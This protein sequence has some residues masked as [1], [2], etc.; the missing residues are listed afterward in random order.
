MRV[1]CKKSL[2]K[3]NTV[4]I[5][6]YRKIKLDWAAV[7]Q[8]AK[9]RHH[10]N[11]EVMITTDHSTRHHMILRDKKSVLILRIIQVAVFWGQDSSTLFVDTFSFG[12]TFLPHCHHCLCVVGV[13]VCVCV[14]MRACVRA[15]VCQN[16][17]S[18]PDE[19][20]ARKAKIASAMKRKVQNR[21]RPISSVESLSS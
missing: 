5:T 13:D 12:A 1:R 17:Q 3:L 21:K 10:A 7:Q 15:C 4:P 8:C 6:G 2:A 19:W 18:V 11:F 14:C 16:E 20:Q 9:L